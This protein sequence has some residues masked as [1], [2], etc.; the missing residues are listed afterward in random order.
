[1]TDRVDSVS[2]QQQRQIDRAALP[3]TLMGD[4]PAMRA[5][6]K[7][8]LPQEP[9]ESDAAY[10][11][12]RQRSTLFNALGKTVDDMTGKVFAKPIVIE[13]DVPD[14]I[15]V[16]L[17][18]VDL[19]GRHMNVFARDV[20]RDAMQTGIGYI[21]T[22][23]PRRPEG[24]ANT[25]AAEA[26]A[27]IR[28][29]LVYIP[30]ERMLGF[31]FEM[32]AGVATLTMIRFRE[33]VTEADGEFGE[34]TVEQIRVIEPGR[35][36]TFR[37]ADAAAIGRNVGEWYEH[38][39]GLTSLSKIPLA[40]VYLNR[41]GYMEGAPPLAKLAEINVAHW[42][43][44]SD[45]RN[46]LHVARVPILFGAGFKDDDEIT[47]GAGTLIR[48]SDPNAKLTYVE[49]TGKA[50][51]AG[52]DELANLEFQMQ[53]MGLQLLVSQPRKTATGE[54]RDDAKE[55]SPLA[56][57]ANALQDALEMSLGYMSEFIGLGADAGGSVVVNTDF[58]VRANG[59]DLQHLLDA[60]N[61]D[62]I[63]KKT[64]WAEW[65][66]RG[67]LSDS[68]D[69]DLEKDRINSEAPTLGAMNVD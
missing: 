35:W 2:D 21:L 5:A 4:T 66:R 31:K 28:P 1:M 14:K 9:N 29:Y 34:K 42:Q 54:I 50:I 44:Q 53:T 52:R 36:R 61:A 64:F 8:Y 46:I 24:L 48:N 13:D 56:M 62:Q 19:A 69:A 65:Q 25:Q 45:Q 26:D 57:M 63:S 41:T 6:G 27:G 3:R 38:E 17:E 18:N 40:P 58:G 60:V 39:S 68:F 15:K 47:V 7:T 49:H 22:D 11:N 20:F 32:L 55:N 33:H 67:V 59:A 16:C 43:S 30:L 37:K 10:A 51:E 23:M 12:R